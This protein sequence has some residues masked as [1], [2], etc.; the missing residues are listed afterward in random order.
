MF[1]NSSWHVHPDTISGWAAAYSAMVTPYVETLHHPHLGKKMSS[2]D[3]KY[4]RVDGKPCWLFSVMCTTTRFVISRDTSPI[5]IGYYDATEL[6]DK[7]RKAA[8]SCL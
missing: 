4:K 2:A 6:L 8:V 3:E 1:K 7:A 5:K